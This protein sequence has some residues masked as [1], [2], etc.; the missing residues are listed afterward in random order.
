MPTAS[1][2]EVLCTCSASCILHAWCIITG[3]GDISMGTKACHISTDYT[4]ECIIHLQ[5]DTHL[6]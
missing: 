4:G 5:N 3:D 2:R 6:H 1:T